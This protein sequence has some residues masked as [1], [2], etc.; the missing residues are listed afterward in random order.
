MK[1]SSL[2]NHQAKQLPQHSTLKSLAGTLRSEFPFHLQ[3]TN[4][5]KATSL[6]VKRRITHAASTTK[7]SVVVTEGYSNINPKAFNKEA[8]ILASFHLILTIHNT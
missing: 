5:Q 8:G 2:Q 1:P 3:K 6:Q 4:Q 7:E